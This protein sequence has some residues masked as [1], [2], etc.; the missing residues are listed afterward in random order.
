ML[1]VLLMHENDKVISTS[2]VNYT[3]VIFCIT[4]AEKHSAEKVLTHGC[5]FLEQLR[6]WKKIFS[7]K[8]KFQ[9]FDRGIFRNFVLKIGIS[10]R[11]GGENVLKNPV[12][13]MIK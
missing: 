5:N 6:N 2:E 4:I 10:S 8:K 3:Y 9:L 13:N 12:S 1:K 11:F 7:C